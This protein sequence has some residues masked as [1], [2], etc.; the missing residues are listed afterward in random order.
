MLPA[1][2]H[3]RPSGQSTAEAV[4]LARTSG[5]VLWTDDLTVGDV[6]GSLGKA[7]RAWTQLVAMWLAGHG[8]IS[9]D[10][11]VDITIRLLQRGYYWTRCSPPAV[12]Q[13]AKDG[14]WDPKAPPLARVVEH[15]AEPA[16]EPE[17]LTMLAG[18]SFARIIAEAPNGNLAQY[19]ISCILDRVGRRV[20]G[21][22]IIAA[23]LQAAS[24][25]SER[26]PNFE[27]IAVVLHT[28]FDNCRK[29]GIEIR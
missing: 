16:A 22:H 4:A 10:R 24:V 6:A 9:P 28:W 26:N 23:I 18:T 3:D 5:R 27:K 25:A 11:S 29:S 19:L 7:P 1:R 13:A 14:N 17:S 12:I 20:G 21:G 2:E 15:F 8:Y